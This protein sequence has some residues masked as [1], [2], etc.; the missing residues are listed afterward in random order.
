[1]TNEE[2]KALEE[3]LLDIDILDPIE[4]R[5]A[6]FN[7]FETLS[8]VNTEIR[9]SNVLSWLLTPSENHGLGDF[10]IKKFIQ[11]LV[12]QNK[13][14]FSNDSSLNLF[15]LSLMEYHDFHV[16]REWRNIDL[17]AI[18]DTNNI[19]I[20]IEN[21]I[22]SKESENQ[23]KKYR[24]IIH[25][26]FNDYKHIFVFLTPYGDTPRDEKNWMVFNYSSIL[27]IL[28]KAIEFNDSSLNV[29]VK[30]FIQQYIETLRRYIV[31]DTELEK[32]CRDIYYK[33]QKAFDLIFEYKP[34]IYSEVSNYID[35]LIEA[36]DVVVKDISNKTYTR[37]T[38]KDIDLKIPALGN[39]W[40]ASKRIL[41]F[42]VQNR[43]DKL[44]LKLII[45]PGDDNIREKI[46]YAANQNRELFK[47]M[48]N[49]LTA[50]YSQ[51]YVKEILPKN[52][53]DKLDFEK[54]QERIKKELDVFFDNDCKRIKE[55]LLSI[56]F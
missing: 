40:T 52:Y 37:F 14:N 55:V 12:Y 34:D 3:F 49:N 16:R 13:Y 2:Q 4:S 7:I 38:T 9:H 39:G 10:F 53:V 29:H 54:I 20:V 27:D 41:I 47:G 1:M 32:I 19:V 56:D 43:S 21:K 28:N 42:E 5:L 44:V 36:R 33:H 11:Q 6:K 24:S 35:S 25:E 46:Y 17:V 22:W 26:E 45:G 30:P 31:G 48:L 8:I 51:I 23:L 18:S 50:Q 15:N